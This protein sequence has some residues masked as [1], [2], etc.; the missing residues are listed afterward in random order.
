MH[1]LQKLGS[2]G[3]KQLSLHIYPSVIICI[4]LGT[5]TLLA[6]LCRITHEHTKVLILCQQSLLVELINLTCTCFYKN[7][8][9]QVSATLIS[10]STE[11]IPVHK[12]CITLKDQND[13]SNISHLC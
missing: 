10:Q 4:P 7:A 6:Q 1:L 5:D 3:I 13:M 9:F 2:S 11:I 8:P 12:P